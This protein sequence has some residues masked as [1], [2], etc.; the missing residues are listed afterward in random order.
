MECYN[1][2]AEQ[3]VFVTNQTNLICLVTFKFQV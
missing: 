2:Y 3:Q 1:I